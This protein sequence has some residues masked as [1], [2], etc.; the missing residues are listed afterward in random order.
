MKYQH[1]LCTLLMAL[2]FTGMT[3]Q[4]HTISMSSGKLSILGVNYVVVEGHSGSNVV[5]TTENEDDEEHDD[6]MDRMKG[7]KAING[8]GATDNTGIGLAVTRDGNNATL[9]QI[10][11]NNDQMYSIKVPSGVSV[12]YENS[13]TDGEDILFRN[14]S[15]EIEVSGVYT[16]VVL[17]GVS[18]A[19]SVSTVYGDVD[20]SFKSVSAACSVHTTYGHIDL[21]L[22]STA[23]ASFRLA[24]SYGSMFT[25]LDLKFESEGGEE[26]MKQLSAKKSVAKLNGGG[27]DFSVQATYDNIYLRKS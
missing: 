14:V 9:R 24:T 7:L 2:F 8:A 5:I 13:T 23:K 10:S 11:V 3:A 27:A 22:P 1:L 17:E 26:G 16:G 20:G 12:Y 21:S 18:G 25:D 15:G 6:D 19:V 4:Q